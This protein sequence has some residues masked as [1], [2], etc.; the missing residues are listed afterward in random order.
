MTFKCR[1]GRKQPFKILGGKCS[2]HWQCNSPCKSPE[3]G[4]TEKVEDKVR[5]EGRGLTVQVW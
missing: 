1:I 5:Q 2:R 3:K 4:A